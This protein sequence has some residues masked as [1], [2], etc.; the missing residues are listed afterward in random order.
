MNNDVFYELSYDFVFTTIFNRD[1]NVGKLEKFIAIYFGYTYEQ[2]HNNLTLI[3][4]DLDKKS[5]K[6]AKKQVDLLLTLDNMKRNI[7]IE[8]DR[9]KTQRIKN[10]NTTYIGKIA[11]ELNY[12]KSYKKYKNLYSSRQISFNLKPKINDNNLF[13]DE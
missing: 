1:E 7:S 11:G 10:R 9:N 5:K 4:R 13:I 3:K 2:V 6:E 12:K 8:I